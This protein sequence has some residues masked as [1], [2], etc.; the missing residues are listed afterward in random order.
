L[1]APV[2]EM[3]DTASGP[4]AGLAPLAEEAAAETEAEPA[5]GAAADAPIDSVTEP[6]IA[7]AASPESAGSPEPIAEMGNSASGSIADLL[8]LADREVAPAPTVD[9]DP[10]APHPE[11]I[12]APEPSSAAPAAT[13][14]AVVDES[15]LVEVWRLGRLERPQRHHRPARARTPHVRRENPDRTSSQP[16]AAGDLA[17][18]ASAGEAVPSTGEVADAA[19]PRQDRQPRRQR[20]GRSDQNRSDQ[21]RPDQGR[22]D[23]NP[24][25]QKRPDQNRP[26]RGGRPER[27]GRPER[28]GRGGDHPE[29]DPELRAKY[30]KGR[31]EGRERR[32]K[33][34]DPNSPFAKLAALKEQLEAN[35][36]ERR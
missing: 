6:A 31:G 17:A 29:R 3:G 15:H 28:P 14:D 9:T 21:N 33:A 34:P 27:H 12:V 19:P 16:P 4:V 11:P 1:V 32:D 7:A 18:S 8:P 36:K 25:Q 2:A 13:T 24:S 30:L 5:A 10:S 22:P 26:D 35:A 23:Q 20:H